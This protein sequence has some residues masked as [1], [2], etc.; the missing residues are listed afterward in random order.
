MKKI[1]ASV[2]LVA[3]MFAI[4]A[5]SFASANYDKDPKAAKSETKKDDKKACCKDG[6]AC[7][8]D[9][10]ASTDKKADAPKK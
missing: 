1:I 10:A 7:C 3:F 4:S 5:P 2:A 6:K 9:K 8:K